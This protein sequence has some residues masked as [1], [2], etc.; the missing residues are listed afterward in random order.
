[1][2]SRV[3]Q[4]RAPKYRWHAVFAAVFLGVIGLT[5]GMMAHDWSQ[6]ELLD[7]TG[8]RVS[9]VVSRA[10]PPRG[11]GDGL[12]H[13]DIVYTL[14]GHRYTVDKVPNKWLSPPAEGRSGVPGGIRRETSAGPAVR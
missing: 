13:A 4:I 3:P 14:A 6:A 11:K 1:M 12:T 7:R 5:E 2:T 9:G 10:V 8:V